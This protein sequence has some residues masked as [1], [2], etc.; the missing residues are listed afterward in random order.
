MDIVRKYGRT[1]LGRRSTSLQGKHSSIVDRY[2]GLV[3]PLHERSVSLYHIG[4]MT[5]HQSIVGIDSVFAPLLMRFPVSP[6]TLFTLLQ[7]EFTQPAYNWVS[8]ERLASWMLD[9]DLH[10]SKQTCRICTVATSPPHRY[11]RRTSR[12]FAW[13]RK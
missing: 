7:F 2:P 1:Y 9:S 12:G 5:L 6:L 13:G 4:S 3:T 10:S 8:C 11:T